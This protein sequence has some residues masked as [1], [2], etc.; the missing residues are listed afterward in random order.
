MIAKLTCYCGLEL[1]WDD[2]EPNADNSYGQFLCPA[3]F[4]GKHSEILRQEH[5]TRVL[6]RSAQAALS[7][8]LGGKIRAENL[9]PERRTRIARNA[10]NARWSKT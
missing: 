1:F 4:D 8:S 10:A 2:Q 3:R 5:L 7:G 9:T 6:E